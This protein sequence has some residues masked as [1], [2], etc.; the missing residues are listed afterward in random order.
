MRYVSPGRS[1]V[2]VDV[3]LELLA[4]PARLV[5]A[6]LPHADTTTR[7]ETALTARVGVL[8]TLEPPI[9]YEPHGLITVTVCLQAKGSYYFIVCMPQ[10]RQSR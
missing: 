1:S 3:A 5:V 6:E 7:A 4:G 8:F 2:D 9:L 10:L